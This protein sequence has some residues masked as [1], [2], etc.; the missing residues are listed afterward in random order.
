MQAASFLEYLQT[1]AFNARFSDLPSKACSQGIL[2]II[3]KEEEVEASM[4]RQ[5]QD[6]YLTIMHE[7]IAN[8]PRVEVKD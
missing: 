6:R 7:A 3:E 5:G 4:I 8:S 1:V 2:I